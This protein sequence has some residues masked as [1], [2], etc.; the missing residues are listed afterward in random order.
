[1]VGG[2]LYPAE[3]GA[4]IMN[5]PMMGQSNKKAYIG[6]ARTEKQPIIIAVD[7]DGTL[8][9]NKYPEIGTPKRE[10]IDLMKWRKSMGDKIILWTCRSGKSLDDAVVWCAS[11]GL[12]FD[13]VNENPPEE[14]DKWQS[15]PRKI[16]ADVYIDDKA[17]NPKNIPEWWLD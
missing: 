14:I 10:M 16:G 6:Y 1:M 15:N 4:D 3:S 2:T 5:I 11:K 12:Y 8:C 13:E 7:F 9:E 17:L